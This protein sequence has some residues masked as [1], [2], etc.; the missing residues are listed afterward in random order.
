MVLSYNPL[1]DD[2]LDNDYEWLR[3]KSPKKNSVFFQEESK[4]KSNSPKKET[5]KKSSPKK[6]MLSSPK[7][8][9]SIILT[10][11]NDDDFD[12]DYPWLKKKRIQEQPQVEKSP[13]KLS[14]NYYSGIRLEDYVDD[15]EH[16]EVSV[17]PIAAPPV[18][19]IPPGA[20]PPG[21]V[22]PIAAPPVVVI[23]PGGALPGVGVLRRVGTAA[24]TALGTLGGALAA[25]PRAAAGAATTLVKGTTGVIG[26]LAGTVTS[27]V[28]GLFRRSRTPVPTAPTVPLPPPPPAVPQRLSIQ[29]QPVV[30]QSLPRLSIKTNTNTTLMGRLWS[31]FFPTRVTTTPITFSIIPIV[32]NSIPLINLVTLPGDEPLPISSEFF[33]NP[34][35]NNQMTNVQI[36]LTEVPLPTEIIP[37]SIAPIV[38]N[39]M[40][41]LDILVTPIAAPARAAVVISPPLTITP[42]ANENMPKIKIKLIK[43]I[44]SL[45]NVGIFGFFVMLIIIL[46]TLGR[47]FNIY[48]VR[49]NF[50]AQEHKFQGNPKKFIEFAGNMTEENPNNIKEIIDNVNTTKLIE[51]ETNNTITVNNKSYVLNLEKLEEV[52]NKETKLDT[53]I[54]DTEEKRLNQIADSVISETDAYDTAKESSVSAY[55]TAEESSV[56]NSA[57]VSNLNTTVAVSPVFSNDTIIL[58][59]NSEITEK[60]DEFLSVSNNNNTAKGEEA[61]SETIYEDAL[62]EI[63]EN[64]EKTKEEKFKSS[65]IEKKM[66]IK[67]IDSIFNNTK[68]DSKSG[69]YDDWN[70]K[71][72]TY[73]KIYIHF[74]KLWY[75]DIEITIEDWANE[76]LNLYEK[77]G[78]DGDDPENVTEF[79]EKVIGRIADGVKSDVKLVTENRSKGLIRG[80][81][82][83]KKTRSNRL[84]PYKPHTRSNTR[85][86]RRHNPPPP[87]V[88]D[89]INLPDVPDVADVADVADP[90]LERSDDNCFNSYIGQII[91]YLTIAGLSALAAYYTNVFGIFPEEIPTLSVPV[92][93]PYSFTS[94][95][96]LPPPSSSLVSLPSLDIPSLPVSLP[97]PSNDEVSWC[98]NSIETAARACYEILMKE[99]QNLESLD[100]TEEN[101]LKSFPFWR[102]KKYLDKLFISVNENF[103]IISRIPKEMCSF[104]PPCHLKDGGRRSPRKSKRNNRKKNLS[105][106]QKSRIRKK[107]LFIN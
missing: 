29:I 41:A 98:R 81:M 23:P 38:N 40:S 24:S 22:A 2:E 20:A 88:P 56:N 34:V 52:F 66:D 55:D 7:K 90:V 17:P 82:G 95:P 59:E 30:N 71:L 18:V 64:V 99:I 101:Y 16:Y 3:K 5:E 104:P 60:I 102:A 86:N 35:V 48:E 93:L 46:L 51:D 106:K 32:N 84:Y 69:E 73:N 72:D 14:S 1:F 92:S 100:K 49:D 96:V 105:Q 47:N 53:M 87:P 13:K 26:A 44:K 31:S 103:K 91:G 10:E 15:Y 70:S 8:I 54:K 78:F 97:F 45:K 12:S 28:S 6:Q 89:V 85:S 83:K 75:E 61:D 21:V 37:L 94:S 11:K 25:T 68:L 27:G 77:A 74:K 57:E 42:L 107:T 63:V 58:N 50:K 79:F 76:L 67:L 62:S 33:I 19:V 36:R 4:K 9:K 43:P 39:E 80:A 65:L